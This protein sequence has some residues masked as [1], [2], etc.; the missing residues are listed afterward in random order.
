MSQAFIQGLAWSLA[1]YTRG[2]ALPSPDAPKGE[3]FSTGASWE[4]CA[5]GQRAAS[6]VESNP[7]APTCVQAVEAGQL[8]LA[9]VNLQSMIS[10]PPGEL[11]TGTSKV[12]VII[13]PNYGGGTFLTADI[14]YRR[15]CP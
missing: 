14:Q 13:G 12:A 15:A 4:W 11:R 6:I 3:G 1:Y 8:S 2:S 7:C 9:S 5:A 10:L